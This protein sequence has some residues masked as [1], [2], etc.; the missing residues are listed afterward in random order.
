M[1]YR[2][3]FIGVVAVG[4]LGACGGE[5]QS[6]KIDVAACNTA[7]ITP[8]I[9]QQL[10]KNITES[11][12]QYIA[13]D[14][15][16]FIDADKI[17]AAASQLLVNVDDVAVDN[18]TPTTMCKAALKVSVPN[19]VWQTAQSNAPLVF[20]APRTFTDILNQQ[21]NGS[22]VSWNADVFSQ[23]LSYM[24]AAEAAASAPEITGQGINALSQ[25]LS[26]ALLP[27]GVKDLLTINGKVINRADALKNVNNL[28]SI[29][30][31]PVSASEASANADAQMASAILN[32]GAVLPPNA[33]ATVS[34]DDLLQAQSNSRNATA[35]INRLWRDM[36]GSIR[37]ELTG[38]QEQ[39]VAQK[40]KQCR[41]AAQAKS[42]SEAELAQLNCETQLTNQRINYLRGYVIH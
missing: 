39:W 22:G 41:A 3:G 4:L 38:D 37:N 28:Q 33:V 10:Q 2:F 5:K 26:T 21:V 1:K 20:P 15:R 11:A 9:Q 23:P 16:G 7:L 13:T 34:A 40:E 17:I 6:A 42:G 35:E 25:I 14:S 12:R 32:G 8:S 36:D 31:I 29:P 18:S 19:T 30:E 24:P 27:Y